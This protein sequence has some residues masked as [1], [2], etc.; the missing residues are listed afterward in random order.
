MSDCRDIC[1]EEL[2]SC[3]Q[4]LCNKQDVWNYIKELESTVE[5]KEAECQ[6]LRRQ[7]NNSENTDEQ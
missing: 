5:V 6:R 2:D 4:T 3:C 1:Y 7:L